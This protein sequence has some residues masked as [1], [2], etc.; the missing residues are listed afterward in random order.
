LFQFGYFNKKAF[1]GVNDFLARLVRY[2]KKLPKGYPWMFA[3]AEQ[4]RLPPF[5]R[6]PQ[7]H[8]LTLRFSADSAHDPVLESGIVN[9]PRKEAKP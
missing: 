5:H 4:L 6:C 9:Y 7:G 8:A 3:E 2:V 1:I